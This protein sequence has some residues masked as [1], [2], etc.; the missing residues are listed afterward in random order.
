MPETIEI[1]AEVKHETDDAYLVNDGDVEDW[2]PASQVKSMTLISEKI[3]EI[4]IP[5]WIA[6]D[7]GFI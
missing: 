2:I 3:Y 4:E 7:K 6:R 5:L 1:T